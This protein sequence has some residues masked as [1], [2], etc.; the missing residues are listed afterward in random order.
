MVTSLKGIVGLVFRPQARV[1]RGVSWIS[2][3]LVTLYLINTWILFTHG[4]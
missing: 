1:L 2:F 3:G 4:H